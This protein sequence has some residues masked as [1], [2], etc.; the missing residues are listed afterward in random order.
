[1]HEVRLEA[2]HEQ[3]VITG[4]DRGHLE[5]MYLKLICGGAEV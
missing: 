5:S 2:E 1:M 3:T 4:T